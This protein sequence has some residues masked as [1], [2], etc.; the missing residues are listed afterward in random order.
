[1]V[2]LNLG[3]LELVARNLVRSE[4]L[5]IEEFTEQRLDACQVLVAKTT[6]GLATFTRAICP[7][8]IYCNFSMKKV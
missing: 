6:A 1:M 4:L 3:A 2:H 5:S 8:L 7:D